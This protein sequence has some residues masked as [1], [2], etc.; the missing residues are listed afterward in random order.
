MH[1]KTSLPP[2]REMRETILKR[3]DRYIVIQVNH[4]S[5]HFPLIA[6][7]AVL[8]LEI[9]ELVQRVRIKF[10]QALEKRY[11]RSPHAYIKLIIK[12]EFVDMSRRQKPFLPLPAD[13]ELS[14]S[15]VGVSVIGNMPDPADEVEQQV[16]A[17][18]ILNETIQ[19]A[20]G[21]P[22][23][24]QLALIYSLQHRVD[25][26]AQLTD[27]FKSNKIDIEGIQ[28]PTGKAEK[29]LLQAS[30]TPA[31][32]ALAKKMK[33]RSTGQRCGVVQS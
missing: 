18:D 26:L 30:L 5:R 9:D 29:R 8:D 33:E 14:Y 19:A 17:S 20:L 21:L 12:C 28:W 22:P 1:F 25:D 16:E 31:R 10:W 27:V 7:T 2:E 3:F 11:I 23:R 13:E 32:K 15:G 24:Q 4:Y 6:H